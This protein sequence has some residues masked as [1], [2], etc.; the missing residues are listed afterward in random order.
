MRY[1]KIA[2]LILA[3]LNLPIAC[4]SAPQFSV[5]QDKDW[6]LVEVRHLPEDIVFNRHTLEEEGFAAIFTI[7]FDNTD[8]RVNGIGAPNNYFAPYTLADK[9]GITIKTIAST[10]MFAIHEPE[11]L[12]ERDYFT[13]LQ[14][15][16]RWSLTDG[17]L[18]LYSTGEDGVEALM[19][20]VLSDT[21]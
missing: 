9:Q 20:F 17:N 21:K 2:V 14:N 7:R 1:V 13:Y 4:K 19:T 10:L 8:Q 5:V 12:K 6:Y 18:E 11:K 15:T 16:T 3:V